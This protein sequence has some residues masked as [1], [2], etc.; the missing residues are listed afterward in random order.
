[1]A[2]HIKILLACLLFV[3]SSEAQHLW[4]WQN[5]LPQ[6]N[7]LYDICFVDSSRGW[8]VGL[9]GTVLRTTDGGQ[10]WRHAQAPLHELFI[11]TSFINPNQ[12]WV[13]TYSTYKILRTTD[14]GIT[15]DS[16]SILPFP[17]YLDMLFLNES[18]G[19][20]AGN[21]G[22]IMRTTDGGVTWNAT[23]TNSYGDVYTLHF[24]NDLIGW[25]SGPGRWALK[26]TNGGL[27]W[28]HMVTSGYEPS[29]RRVFSL[30]AQRAYIVGSHDFLGTITGFLYSTANGGATWQARYFDEV[31][32]DVY[33][34]SPNSGWVCDI[35]GVI[36]QT[37]DGGM[38]WTQLNGRSSRFTFAGSR[39]AWG[40]AGSGLIFATDDGWQTY[41]SQTQA[42]TTWILWAVSAL[43]SNR[44][45]ACGVNSLVVGT[46]DGGKTWLQ[47]YNPGNST[48]LMDILY[49][50]ANEI[51][52]VGQG[53]TL[54]HSTDGGT[55]WLDSTL[56]DPWLSGIAFATEDVGYIVAASGTLYRTSDAGKSW[57]VDARFGNTPLERIV[58]SSPTLG[59]IVAD[60]GVHRSTDGGKTWQHVYAT[61]GVPLD[62]AAVGNRAMFPK[63]NTI[64]YTTDAGSTWTTRTVFPLET[65]IY[66]I[67]SVAFADDNN[68][69]G[70]SN[71]GRIYRTTNGGD[72]W[73][74]ESDMNGNSLFGIRFANRN[75]GWAVGRGGA[76]LHFNSLTTSVSE[77]GNGELPKGFAL[78]QNYPNPF[79]PATTI[80]FAIPHTAVVALKVYDILGQE[81]ETLVAGEVGPGEFS[82]QWNAQHSSSGVYFYRLQSNGY[83]E[84][85]RMLLLK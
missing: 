53:G 39:R 47:Y 29:S 83:I 15:W 33:F 81:L 10:Q 16:I 7:T 80:R 44:A 77:D 73:N 54:V 85:K 76:I 22:K 62:V 9:A 45:V 78:R 67:E 40:I 8:A 3:G 51:W 71:N 50:S 64:V 32:T 70:V 75:R 37:T 38:T 69:W 82:V 20:A 28:T 72:S 31:L 61:T 23:Q 11:R 17:Y 18:V 34:F 46:K 21:N 6:G 49:K 14:G 60:D 36:H 13:M 52:A 4:Q 84:T 59:W 68:G 43:D 41:R 48:Y 2:H 66:S 5:P 57:S 58:F 55:S 79:N 24:A 65:S 30:D 42:V 1:M 35:D 74:M 26:T 25:A 12:G 27:T 63:L 56:N 19:F